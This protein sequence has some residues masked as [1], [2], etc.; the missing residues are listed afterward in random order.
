MGQHMGQ[1]KVTMHLYQD[2]LCLLGNMVENE[3]PLLQSS[4]ILVL[5]FVD[6]LNDEVNDLFF[7]SSLILLELC[8]PVSD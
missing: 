7:G 6:S 8:H 2:L 3:H 5:F 4:T 1:Y